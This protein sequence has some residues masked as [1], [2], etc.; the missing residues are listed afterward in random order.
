MAQVQIAIRTN[1]TISNGEYP[2]VIR[3]AYNGLPSKYIRVNG[4]SS[5][6][7][8]WNK[9]LSRFR[10]TK[11]NYKALNLK[12]SEIEKKI[13]DIVE[14]LKLSYE[15]SYQNFKD[16]YL[17]V[18]KIDVSIIG[19]YKQKMSELKQLDKMGTYTFY[20]NSLA[21]INKYAGNKNLVFDDITYQ[22]LNKYIHKKLV[23]GVKSNSIAVYLK[24]LRAIHI[25]HCRENDLPLPTVYARIKIQSLI[26]P[27]RKRSLLLVELKRFMAYVPKSMHEQLAMDVFM[28]SFY[29]RGINL[30]D[31]AK[32]TSANL[33]N[34]RIEYQRSKTSGEF[35]IKIIPEV[36]TILDQ[37]NG[38]ESLLPVIK[39]STIPFRDAVKNYNKTLNKILRRIAKENKL[40][41][42][43]SMYWARHTF[44]QM[45]RESGASIE[46]ISAALGHADLKT[47]Q[48]YLRSFSD[49]EVDDAASKIF[50]LL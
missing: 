42:D 4:L 40:P 43:L 11:T 39:N 12:L 48:T 16:K 36:Q 38:K 10:K 23:D 41:K 49:T 1:K 5:T 29:C 47:T 13:D 15:F 46:V 20:E 2:V 9:E 35:S 27:T 19:G 25:K 31:I 14:D 18:D 32:L 44:A 37:Y 50:D 6:K 28:F 33:V 3:V 22:F 30:M 34:G 24:G 7:K 45:S 17:G 8:Q 26:K 21:S